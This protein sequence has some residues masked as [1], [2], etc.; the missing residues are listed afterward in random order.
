MKCDKE[1]KKNAD[2]FFELLAKHA[3][4]SPFDAQ[5]QTI[6]KADCFAVCDR[7]DETFKET[8]FKEFYEVWMSAYLRSTIGKELAMCFI[9]NGRRFLRNGKA[10]LYV[11]R[12]EEQKIRE[13][14]RKVIDFY[15]R[16]RIIKHRT[17]LSVLMQQFSTPIPMSFLT[18][19]YILWNNRAI[20]VTDS[21]EEF[22]D[23]RL[24]IFEP[25]AGNALLLSCLPNASRVNYVLN[26]LDDVRNS[27]LTSLHKWEKQIEV[28][29]RRASS[30][31]LYQND[32]KLPESLYHR[33]LGASMERMSAV[34][35]NPPFGMLHRP[36]LLEGYT[37]KKIE[38]AIALN[39]LKSLNKRGRAAIIIGGPLISWDD[40]YDKNG[41]YTSVTRPFY[42]YLYS[43]YNVEDI[44]N[45]DG[46]LYAKQGTTSNVRLILIN[47]KKETPDDNYAP[48]FDGKHKVVNTW[49]KLFDRVYRLCKT[50]AKAAEIPKNEQQKQQKIRIANAN[51]NAIKLLNLTFDSTN[52]N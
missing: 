1:Y 31:E 17:G 40:L 21:G 13:S 28:G 10:I 19:L 32:A 39:A 49:D 45:I 5:C 11:K 6:A 2:R 25:C 4:N 26:E 14:F 43:H 12:G 18:N 7:E 41:H 47:G 30:M 44:I 50:C 16:Q 24:N 37:I 38:H 22:P 29:V 48:D 42:N 35:A 3:K 36:M 9:V 52:V 46:K 34:L 15:E 27:A 8:F 20:D 51:A 33:F 23:W